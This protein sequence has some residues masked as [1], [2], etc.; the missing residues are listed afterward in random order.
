MSNKGLL[1]TGTGSNAG[2][3][4]VVTAIIRA[5]ANDGV[6]VAPFK[7]Q[8]MAL[9][10]YVTLDGKEIGRAQASQA[11]AAR[12]EATAEMNPVLLKPTSAM[13]SSVIVMGRESETLSASAFQSRKMELTGIVDGAFKALT[14][15]YDVVICEGAGSPA[16]INLASNDL[17]NLGF[18]DRVGISSI[19]VGDIDRGGVFASLFGTKTIL[20]PE[21]SSRIR[22]FVI[23][24]FRGD[25]SL[26]EPGLTELLRLTSTPTIGV[27]P[28][29]PDMG[30]D[31]EDSLGLLELF[32][33]RSRSING[34][35]QGGVPCG[36]E[37]G[38]RVDSRLVVGILNLAY[39]S[40]FNDFEPLAKSPLVDLRLVSD[41]RALR[42]IDLL[43]IPGSKSTVSDL[44][45]L[46]AAGFEAAI[47]G[48]VANGGGLFGICGG[49]QMLMSLINDG[50]ESEY[51]GYKGLD[52]ISGTV[53]FQG[54]K[55]L[56]R[57]NGKLAIAKSTEV[58]VEGYQIHHGIVDRS[59]GNPLFYLK[60]PDST[61]K[62]QISDAG[63]PSQSS[64]DESDYLEEG[65]C[66]GAIGGT[67]LHGLFENDQARNG[68]LDYFAQRVNKHYRDDFSYG[69]IREAYFESAAS[70]I[71]EN[72][73]M[74]AIYSMIGI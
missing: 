49:Y 4:F 69:L 64:L 38:K 25:P 66:Q 59:P 46:R 10:S 32:S 53:N 2:K 55:T 13:A 30:V 51:M 7:G 9:N 16:E 44:M 57:R 74:S 12:I 15:S 54:E 11:A 20:A 18:A 6:S 28:Y 29:L 67:T 70:L 63:G 50:V 72:L 24:K 27:I 14:R 1:V 41:P 35:F 37:N 48:F 65:Y 71:Q 60:A 62:A 73:S 43:I 58:Y 40:N 17:V 33:P 8:N 5:L 45:A 34:N 42:G 36:D 31:A 22:A 56:A 21:L 68:I 3:S 52:L 39:L 23:N 61:Q 19:L 47:E 26:L